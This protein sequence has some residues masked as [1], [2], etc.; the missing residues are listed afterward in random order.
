MIP[1]QYTV[2][3]PHETRTR[4]AG[5]MATLREGKVLAGKRLKHNLTGIEL[6]VLTE[7]YLIDALLNTKPPQIFAESEVA[8][9]GSDWNLTE[10]SILGDIS[11]AL[12]VT[13]FD[14]GHHTAPVAHAE[15]FKGTLVFTPGAL[16]RNGRS[17]KPADWFEVTLENNQLDH[18]GYN[19]LY[20]RRLLPVF[21]YVNDTAK[22]KGRPAFVTMPG[23]GCGQ[24]AGPFRGQLG[25]ALQT[26]L[27]DFL[28]KHGASLP[29][30]KAVYYDPFNECTNSRQ[31]IHGISLMVRPLLQENAE[32]SQLCL[33]TAYAED[34]DDF[35]DCI[36]FSIVA[37]DHV[38]W[39]GNDYFGGSRC[40]D[41][42][43][44]A[45]AT[46]SMRA[47]TGIEGH[48]DPHR[49]AY[50]PPPPYRTWGDVVLQNGL[51]L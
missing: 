26:A 42:G 14:N 15:P 48:Y 6:A 40:T 36:L 47:L 31:E 49:G 18:D 8:G 30:L 41:D 33:P 9:D 23:L 11:I 7:P 45:A 28:K 32:K 34:G 10:L 27:V 17:Q 29:H 46:D 21:H 12:P 39:P 50:L 25:V 38:S 4:V 19:R 3:I 51:R 20:E 22:E 13:I 5:Y 16:L 43:V 1:Q 44:K 2:L 24:F 37:W 35:S